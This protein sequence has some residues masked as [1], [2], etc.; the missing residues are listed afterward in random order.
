MKITVSQLRRIIKEEVQR[1]LLE[2]DDIDMPV[3][4][5]GDTVRTKFE[6]AQ[7]PLRA[8]PSFRE[9][10]MK[11]ASLTDHQ[12]VEVLDVAVD[13]GEQYVLIELPSG[14]QGWAL[15]S[16]LVASVGPSRK[17]S[18]KLFAVDIF[19]KN[20]PPGK[21]KYLRTVQVRATSDSEAKAIFQ[22][23][24]KLKPGEYVEIAPYAG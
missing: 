10:P 13:R 19:T 16:N 8:N 2:Q 24:N 7:V 1:T 5:V 21:Q 22:S 4:Q 23:K 20:P 15:S 11:N 17:G 3:F 14:D 18:M 12:D 6:R 9:L